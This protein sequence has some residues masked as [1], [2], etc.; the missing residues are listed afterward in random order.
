MSTLGKY[1]VIGVCEKCGTEGST[2]FKY[3]DRWLCSAN[4]CI[5]EEIERD[6][7]KVERDEQFL[8]DYRSIVRG[9]RSD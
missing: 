2:L 5:E 1:S 6:S 3:D 9:V 7:D 4:A 8:E